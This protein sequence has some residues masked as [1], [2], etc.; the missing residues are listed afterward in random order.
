MFCP[1]CGNNMPDPLAG[2]CTR[3]GY[4]LTSGSAQTPAPQPAGFPPPPPQLPPTP[5]PQVGGMAPVYSGPVFNYAPWATRALG[6]LVD[7]VIVSVAGGALLVVSLMFFGGMGMAGLG[8]GLHSSALGGIGIGGCCCVFS[9]LPIALL[10]TGLWNKVYLVSQRGCSVGQGI[11]H[12]KVVDA[13]GQFLSQGTALL[14]LLAHVGLSFVPFLGLIDLLWP[15]WDERRQ[16]L[17]DKAVGC[18]VVMAA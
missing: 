11:V 18:Y 15:L 4:R 10:L 17:H 12:V 7:G 6:A 13:Q 5:T 8:G 1:Q 3:C 16:T 14:R 9:I 2:F